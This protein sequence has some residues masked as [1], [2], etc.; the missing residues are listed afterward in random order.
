MEFKT[1]GVSLS[2]QDKPIR[3]RMAVRVEGQWVGC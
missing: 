3:M 2:S 1:V